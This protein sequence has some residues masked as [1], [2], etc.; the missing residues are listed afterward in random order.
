MSA[1]RLRAVQEAFAPKKALLAAQEQSMAGS[2]AL[3]AKAGRLGWLSAVPA[4]ISAFSLGKSLYDGG[5]ADSF[6]AAKN[7]LTEAGKLLVP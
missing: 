5:D 4:A 1:Q 6:T 3:K 2:R 7:N